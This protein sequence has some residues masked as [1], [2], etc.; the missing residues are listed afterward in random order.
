MKSKLKMGK[1]ITLIALVITII[2]LLILAGVTIST[3]TGENGIL[4][5]AQ[6][7]KMLTEEKEEEEEEELY[8]IEEQ[9]NELTT[10]DVPRVRDANPGV[11]EGEGTEEKPYEI[12]SI[13]DLVAFSKQV[14]EGNSFSG[15]YVKLIKSLDFK[16]NNSYVDP[17]TQEFGDVNLD[18]RTE[19]LKIELSNGQGFVPIGNYNSDPIPFSGT[20]YGNKKRVKNLYINVVQDNGEFDAGLF[21][22]NTGTI[23]DLYVLDSNI[24]VESYAVFVGGIAG[25]Q[26]G[27]VQR[28]VSSGKLIAKAKGFFARSRRNCRTIFCR[29]NKY[30]NR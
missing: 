18:G 11:L 26:D 20:F 23:Q 7:A 21:G 29:R 1:G 24:Y 30:I 8:N 28:C 19:G 5:K 15:K 22:Y 25:V 2:V 6:Y 3:L 4:T 12:N 17:E 10:G 14:N 9:M 16:S 13:E 27:I